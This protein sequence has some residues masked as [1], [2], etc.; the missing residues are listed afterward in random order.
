MGKGPGAAKSVGKVSV[1]V[2]PDTSHV[3]EE[4]EAQLKKELAGFVIR[5]PVKVDTKQLGQVRKQ[6]AQASNDLRDL[7]FSKSIDFD[8]NPFET[9]IARIVTGIHQ[10]QEGLKNVLTRSKQIA[11]SFR[12]SVNVVGRMRK[13]WQGVRDEVGSTGRTV[14]RVLSVRAF[15]SVIG[16][17]QALG[18][19]FRNVGREARRGLSGLGDLTVSVSRGLLSMAGSAV[20]ATAALIPTSRAGLILF[21]VLAAGAP[22][23]GLISGLL[24]GLPS[25]V[26]A[27]AAPIAAIALGFDGIKQAASVLKDDVDALKASLSKNFAE[28]MAPVFEQLQSIFPVLDRGL[29]KV[30]DG[31]IAWAQAFTDVVTS[32]RGS[33]QIE[34]ILNNVGKLFQQMTPFVTNF[35]QAF[36]TMA[37]AG[38]NQFGLLADVLNRFAKSFNEMIDRAVGSGVFAK[39]I[40][41]LAMVTESLLQLFVRLF[42]AGLQVM[43]QIGGP[44]A[45][46]INAL[47]NALIPLI[48]ILGAITNLVANVLTP[49]LNVLGQVFTVLGPPIQAILQLLGTAFAGIFQALAP[50][51]MAVAHVI[52]QVLTT[53]VQVLGPILQ[54]MMPI[55]QQIGQIL[56]NVILAVFKALEPVIGPIVELFGQ[57][58]L[59]I[60]QV[61]VQAL[62]A[63]APLFEVLVEFIA[64]VAKEIAPIMPDI[65][66][67][68][69]MI[70]EVLVDAIKL[71]APILLDIAKAV[72]PAV[73]AAI[74]ALIPF[75]RSVITVFKEIVGAIMPI[76]RA[77]VN[78]LMP[79]FR[80][81]IEVARPI[82]DAIVGVIKGA[83]DIIKGIFDFFIGLF[84]GDWQR[85]W[86]GIKGIFSGAWNA[87][88]S[89][90]KG[91]VSLLI[92]F[93]TT[94]PGAILSAL[95]NLL[96][97]LWQVG[98]DIIT[99]LWDG[100]KNAAVAVW[101]WLGDIKDTILGFF[102]DVG[103]WL[104]NVGKDLVMGLWNG[105]K[106]YFKD[107]KQ[108]VI[109]DSETL[110]D[111]I[112]GIFGTHSPST[113]FMEIGKNLG[114]GLR[115]GI[116]SQKNEVFA[117]G[118]R[119]AE[120]VTKGFGEPTVT[121]DIA[122][123]IEDSTPA[124]LKAVDSFSAQAVKRAQAE[125][126]GQL[127]ADGAV[128]PIADQIASAL[129]G[130]T[131]E[132][133]SR[134]VGKLLNKR[135][136]ANK[137]RG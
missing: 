34:T 136:V 32:A 71:V 67:L 135:A 126:S 66:E 83:F 45:G 56:A 38:S 117:A 82:F 41:G 14:T 119:M 54:Q 24:A 132:M 118:N 88:V 40:E 91:A 59:I 87:I 48:P 52:A 96:K 28:G 10:M 27:F 33:A 133:D 60:A 125:F 115:I 110:I 55:L 129:E 89:A 7:D 19:G 81:I 102:K 11:I 20:K 130:V 13:Y 44:L 86:D 70:G 90:V 22:I 123:S 101:D 50:I 61:L 93:V 46:L 62:E 79:A 23:L 1:R 106:R 128:V 26:F 69:K 4:I 124:A 74:K 35:T 5:V 84:T 127:L 51:I 57:L 100:I 8:M 21:A 15:K 6:L 12:D 85:M 97:L 58:A 103:N 16:S 109:D 116:D 105:W 122:K 64:D 2:V 78:A 68:A 30:A 95:G 134:P 49:V 99:G 113:V 98:V 72:L 53:A 9:A 3:R 39:A 111:N 112:R 104:F 37:E 76:V 63:L 108:A 94:I 131:V 18:R 42:D 29:N 36:L 137:R 107:F 114:Q 92:D 120:N 73:L 43:G 80:A 77:I 47:G 25:L 75:I 65:A 121:F 31:T 17:V